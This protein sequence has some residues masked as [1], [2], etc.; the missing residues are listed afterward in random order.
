MQLLRPD[1]VYIDFFK[2]TTREPVIILRGGR[3]SG[4]TLAHMWRFLAIASHGS[5]GDVLITSDTF[6]NLGKVIKDFAGIVGI[7]PQYKQA[8]GEYI[9]RYKRMTFRFRSFNRP[10]D[11][12]GT[13]MKWLYINELDG[14]DKELY[15]M[16]EVGVE[17]QIVCDM[18]PTDSDHWCRKLQTPANTLITS[19]LHNSFLSTEQKQRFKKIE[20]EGKDAEI[21]SA[22]Y[23][24]Y[25]NEILGE[26]A[27]L[28]GRVFNKVHHIDRATFDRHAFVKYLGIDFGDTTAPNALCSVKFDYVNKAIYIAEELYQAFVADSVIA[29]RVNIIRDARCMVYEN[30]M[31]GGTRVLNMHQ[32]PD[33]DLYTVPIVKMDV[34]S[35]VAE[36]ALWTIYVCGENAQSEFKDYKVKEGVYEGARNIIDAARYVFIMV[37]MRELVV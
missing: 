1:Q 19:Y 22:E 13:R 29:E 7:A 4:K 11:A 23:K 36:M 30:A 33:F 20:E 5:G 31:A 17:G 25:A 24:R 16:L 32:N 37:V 3:R 27:T 10:Q 28:G 12:K 15:E 18:N 34:D 8:E 9:A 26:Y 21:G 2:A 35:S 14:I 6:P